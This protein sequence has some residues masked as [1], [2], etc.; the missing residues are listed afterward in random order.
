[1]GGDDRERSGSGSVK[2]VEAVDRSA[3]DAERVAGARKR[4]ANC[5]ILISSLVPVAIKRTVLYG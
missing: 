2:I 5:P 4:I 3:R 1:M